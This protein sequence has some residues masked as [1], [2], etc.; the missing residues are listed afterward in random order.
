MICFNQGR[1]WDLYLGAANCLPESHIL[2]NELLFSPFK[3]ELFLKK[4][5]SCLKKLP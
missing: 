5:F 3:L 4:V 2:P 1:K